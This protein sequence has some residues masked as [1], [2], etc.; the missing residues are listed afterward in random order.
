M[1]ILNTPANV[2]MALGH[3]PHFIMIKD[4]PR[5]PETPCN[6]GMPILSSPTNVL[7]ALGHNPHLIMIGDDPRP[8]QTHAIYECLHL[9]QWLTY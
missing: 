3:N 9:V 1:P 7:M 6:I 5:L 2:L 4:D 8:S